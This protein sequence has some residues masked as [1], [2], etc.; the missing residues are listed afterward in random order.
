MGTASCSSVRSAALYILFLSDGWL[1][2]RVSFF[3]SD[4]VLVLLYDMCALCVLQAWVIPEEDV[5]LNR[6]LA[7]GA[8]GT[9]WSG[10]YANQ[11]P[12]RLV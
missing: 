2:L 10:R 1:V 8:F 3:V 6:Q 5:I 9:V 12:I 4:K 11:A 7:S